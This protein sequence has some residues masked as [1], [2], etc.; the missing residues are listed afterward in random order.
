[1]DIVRIKKRNIPPELLQYFRLHKEG[2]RWRLRNVCIW[3]KPNVMPSSVR[4]R[5]T[6][7]YEPIFFFT[8]AKK[9]WFEPQYEPHQEVSIK[10]AEYGWNR[11]K[12]YPPEANVPENVEKMG[13]RFVNP[14][15]RNKRTVWK[16]PTQP[17]SEAHF[18]TFPEALVVTPIKAGCPEMICKKCGVAREKIFEREYEETKRKVPP[19]KN[20]IG[21]K[22]F[23]GQAAHMTRD[24]FIP[25]RE[26]YIKKIGLTDCNCNAGWNKGIVLD[27]F[28]GS[29]TVGKVA[30]E[31]GR[32]WIGIEINPQYIQF[33][34]DR[35]AQKVLL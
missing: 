16:I 33:G 26:N 32:N 27:P 10:R 11:G 12:E 34:K 29:G 30:Q 14:L 13:E 23:E 15:G 17:Y 25:N 5:F 3:H 20:E 21:S 8:K 9:Y 35:T 2:D 28:C 1:M 31:L 7:D 24:G 18:A 22:G 19:N 4:D 6:V